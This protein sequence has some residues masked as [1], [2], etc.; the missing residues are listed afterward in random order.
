MPNLPARHRAFQAGIAEAEGEALSFELQY[1][2]WDPEKGRTEATS[3]TFTC[4]SYMP[5]ATVLDLGAAWDQERNA[6]NLGGIVA[7]FRTVL[8]KADHERFMELVHDEEAQ[9]SSEL[10]GEI[11]EWLMETYNGRPTAPSSDSPA[12]ALTA[13]NGSTAPSPSEEVTP[14]QSRLDDS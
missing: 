10:L 12:G 4:K 7:F 9:V 2:K 8:L 6:V 13:G 1:R 5:A 3:E 11:I 14:G